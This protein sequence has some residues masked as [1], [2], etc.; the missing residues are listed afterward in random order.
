MKKGRRSLAGLCRPLRLRADD[1][2]GH[3]AMLLRHLVVGAGRKTYLLPT[4][5]PQEALSS[6]GQKRQTPVSTVPKL[7]S[8]GR[9]GWR[10]P[11][12]LSAGLPPGPGR[13]T[14]TG[15]PS[16]VTLADQEMRISWHPSASPSAKRRSR[17]SCG[18]AGAA[19]EGEG[20]PPFA[21]PGVVGGGSSCR[22][23]AFQDHT[24]A[25]RATARTT[26]TTMAPPRRSQLRKY[27]ATRIPIQPAK[28]RPNNR[29]H[30]PPNHPLAVTTTTRMAMTTT[31]IRFLSL[32]R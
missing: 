21:C 32:V 26:H 2:L 13:W 16:G 10:T 3:G 4:S 8:P 5:T 23:F 30:R 6:S 12:G 11:A 9:S 20:A 19:T 7:T 28:M 15:P 14:A 29:P 25:P 24:M 17:G 22:A 1:A 31:I 27:A 18:A